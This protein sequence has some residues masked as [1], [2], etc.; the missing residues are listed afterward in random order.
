MKADFITSA[1]E[2]IRNQALAGLEREK[3]DP[4]ED[5]GAVLQLVASIVDDYQ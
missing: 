3:L 1:Y 4:R 2:D 5:E